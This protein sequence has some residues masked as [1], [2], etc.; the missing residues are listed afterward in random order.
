VNVKAIRK[1]IAGA[2]TTGVAAL[3]IAGQDGNITTHE[4]YTILGAVLF[5]FAGVWVAPRNEEGVS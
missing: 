5:G 3:A 1:A 2:I 4:W